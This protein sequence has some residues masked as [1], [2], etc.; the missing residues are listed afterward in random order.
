MG[1]VGSARGWLAR[2]Y[3]ICLS[4]GAGCQFVLVF[5]QMGIFSSIS[6]F[7]QQSKL[8]IF[9]WCGHTVPKSSKDRSLSVQVLLKS[10]PASRFCCLMAKVSCKTSP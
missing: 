4:V 3:L 1:F 8:G 9:S 10:L 2:D 5:G 6:L 7:I